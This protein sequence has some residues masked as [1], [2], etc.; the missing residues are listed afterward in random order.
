MYTSNYV[1]QCLLCV[2]L[3][4]QPVHS[5]AHPPSS[6][7]DYALKSLCHTI[8]LSLSHCQF[9]FQCS[10]VHLIGLID[11]AIF[12]W[13]PFSILLRLVYTTMLFL[14]CC[15]HCLFFFFF[16]CYLTYAHFLCFLLPYTAM[17]FSICH[18]PIAS[19]SCSPYILPCCFLLAICPLPLFFFICICLLPLF[20]IAIYTAMLFLT[21]HMWSAPFFY[22]TNANCLW[23]L[24]CHMYWRTVFYLP[25]A[26]C[27]CLLLPHILSCYFLLS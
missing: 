16:F 21:C 10:W 6:S 12:F 4:L 9:R 24:Y 2:R 8:F 19:V 22:L 17:L 5:H 11:Y 20:A 15:A 25:G 1:L 18:M 14:T 26:H 27:L 3:N 7:Y 13:V 23:F